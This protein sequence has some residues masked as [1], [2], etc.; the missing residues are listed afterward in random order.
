[1]KALGIIWGVWLLLTSTV[2]SGW[3]W[4]NLFVMHLKL[5]KFWSCQGHC[6]QN[7]LALKSNIVNSTQVDNLTV[8]QPSNVLIFINNIPIFVQQ[9][10]KN[11]A[12]PLCWS[13]TDTITFNSW[14][15]VSIEQELIMKLRQ[16][17]T[18]CHTHGM[19]CQWLSAIFLRNTTEIY[20]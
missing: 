2:D 18:K 5:F 14:Y 16:W 3:L 10:I 19:Y 17:M 1:M 9:L 4:N 6:S 11:S 7:H 8:T 20:I 13:L 12:N 15:K